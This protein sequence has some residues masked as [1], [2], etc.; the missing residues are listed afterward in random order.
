MQFEDGDGTLRSLPASWTS[1]ASVD[2]Y[3]GRPGGVLEYFLEQAGPQR[4]AQREWAKT[5][6]DLLSAGFGLEE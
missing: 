2:P 5:T 4:E 3:S 6:P 1:V